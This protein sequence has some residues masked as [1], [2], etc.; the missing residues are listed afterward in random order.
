MSKRP[1]T[2]KDIAEASG[3]SRATVSAVLHGKDWV[4]D[5]TRSRVQ[6]ALRH[7]KY[8]HHLVADSLSA[9]FSKIVGVVV[10]N[11]RNPFNTELLVGMQS[12]LERAGY[13]V[14]QHTTD[15]SYENEVKALRALSSY[16]PGA[17]VL[18]PVQESKNHAHLRELAQSG[19]PLVT[20]GT[21]PGLDT[22]SVDFD[23]Q[24]GCKLATDYLIEQGHRRIACVAGAE[25][26]SFAKHRIFG[27]IESLVDHGIPLDES[28]IVRADDTLANGY[29][30]ARRALGQQGARP[31]ALVCFNDL[32]AMAA[33]RAAHDEGLRIP[34]DLSI[35]GF[36]DCFLAP[37]MGPPL[38]TVATYPA[39]LGRYIAEIIVTVHTDEKRRGFIR[40]R[41]QPKLIIRDSVAPP[42][43]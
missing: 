29:E 34:E 24:H 19:R 40:R 2:L 31:T 20:I 5:G 23:D 21:V 32:I 16:Q 30:A 17:Y 9:R 41:T 28:L 38:A 18:A 14:I 25:T 27:Y 11:I 4:S 37:V 10:G 26:S 3:V 22:H 6:A 7:N 8:H 12:E 1:V 13:F 42:S 39:K 36:D 43:R 33:Y 15:E 35:I